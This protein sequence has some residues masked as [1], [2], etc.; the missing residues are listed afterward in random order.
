M[1]TAVRLRLLAPLVAGAITLGLGPAAVAEPGGPSQ[2][3]HRF[4][5]GRA[6]Q[7]RGPITVG[8][9][10]LRPCSVVAHAWCGHLDRVWE[11]GHP[12]AGQIHVGVAFAPARDASRPALG[13]YVPHEGGPGYATTGTGSSY[14]AMYGPLLQRHNL[15]LV[16][17]RG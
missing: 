17:Q 16:D 13:T 3:Q 14:A 11:P 15:L 1:L 6:Q 5:D 8:S 4:T 9:L 12:S 10:T 7:A 2:Y